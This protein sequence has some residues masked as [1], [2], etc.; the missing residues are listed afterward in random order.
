MYIHLHFAG[1]VAV[2]IQKTLNSDIPYCP[3]LTGYVAILAGAILT[4]LVQSSSVFTA[5]LTP[6][7]GIGVI[8]VER[9][10]PL[11][12]G[13]NL[14]IYHARAIITTFWKAKNI[15]FRFLRSPSACRT[16]GDSKNPDCS[17]QN[18]PHFSWGFLG[19]L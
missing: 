11:T 18:G 17:C 5:T 1:A 7:V 9:V 10:Y 16:R 8:S 4:F 15:Y 13:S 6:L 19:G 3:W 14:G 12:L 2:I